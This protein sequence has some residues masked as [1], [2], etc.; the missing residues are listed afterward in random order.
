[1]W[2]WQSDTRKEV[3]NANEALEEN[4]SSLSNTDGVES[5]FLF[6][7]LRARA[8]VLIRKMTLQVSPLM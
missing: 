3:T 4:L 5:T 6:P 1:L 2:H 7:D 8:V